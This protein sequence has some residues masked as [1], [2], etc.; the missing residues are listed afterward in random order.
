MNDQDMIIGTQDGTNADIDLNIGFV[1]RAVTVW[2][3][4]G[5]SA[6]LEWTSDMGAGYG[7]KAVDSGTGTTDLSVITSLGITASVI[8][9]DT[10]T[11]FTIGADTDI[12]VSGEKLCY[13]AIR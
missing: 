3:V 2:N 5:E 7:F 1:P 4:E 9:T 10:F 12:N 11:G 8:G 13:K 6:V